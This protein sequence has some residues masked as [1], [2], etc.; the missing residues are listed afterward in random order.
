M[1]PD[2]D[3][4]VTT[5]ALLPRIAGL[6]RNTV[7]ADGPRPPSD[8]GITLP[9]RDAAQTAYVIY[10]SGSTGDPKGVVVSD[11][12]LLHST[13]ARVR[14]YGEAPTRVPAPSELLL[15]QLHRGD[16]LDARRRAARSSL[17]TPTT[18]GIPPGSA[19]LIREE[20][21]SPTSSAFRRSTARC[22]AGAP[23]IFS[24]LARVI[25]AGESCPPQLVALH[26]ERPA[27]RA[28]FNEYGPTEASV[29][30]TVHACTRHDGDATTVPIGRP[31]PERG[32]L[33]ARQPSAVRCQSAST[34]ELFLGGERTCAGLSRARRS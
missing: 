12:N 15:R 27:G 31:D 16:L 25:V 18:C 24:S 11:R 21:V 17:P 19:A 10:T 9:A 22:S 33:R 1:T 34:G 3:T 8:E 6:V 32:R 4:A 13:G 26:H 20:R 23:T 2:I 14:Y 5:S 28:L 29:W 30:A 7:L